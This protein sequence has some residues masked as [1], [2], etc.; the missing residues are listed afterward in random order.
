LPPKVLGVPRFTTHKAAYLVKFYDT[1]WKVAESN[2]DKIIGFISIYTFFPSP[3]ISNLVI[4]YSIF[5]V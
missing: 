1:N 5:A 3:R 2:P 4:G